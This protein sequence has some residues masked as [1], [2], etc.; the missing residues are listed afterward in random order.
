MKGRS[1]AA[2]LAIAAGVGLAAW[3]LYSTQKGGTTD[4]NSSPG[5]GGGYN[6]GPTSNGSRSDSPGDS[7][8]ASREVVRE[9]VYTPQPEDNTGLLDFLKRLLP[10][11][12]DA[13][14][15]PKSSPVLGSG[16]T[17]VLSRSDSGEVQVQW[18]P[19]LDPERLF[20]TKQ[21]SPDRYRDGSMIPEYLKVPSQARS[22]PSSFD[23]GILVP[24]SLQT[25]AGAATARS[26]P[27][28]TPT[29]SSSR[30]S[31]P[32]S[33]SS[34]TQREVEARLSRGESAA[35]VANRLAQRAATN[36]DN[37]VRQ[38]PT[39]KSASAAIA[40]HRKKYGVRS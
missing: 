30:S 10:S 22:T 21:F 27:T 16:T 19:T 9:I 40:Y 15:V 2:G 36:A 7:A 33:S 4:T 20:P 13:P 6:G 37:N 14:T 12:N 18:L 11:G 29:V 35:S 26:T 28:E 32:S 39:F 3:S 24:G 25:L 1:V 38:G 17:P 34:T 8:E 5:Y 23:T 31:S